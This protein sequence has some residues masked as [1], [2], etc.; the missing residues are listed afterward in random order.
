MRS[1]LIRDL[2]KLKYAYTY[3]YAYD[4]DYRLM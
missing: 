4:Y 2:R 3:M 1:P